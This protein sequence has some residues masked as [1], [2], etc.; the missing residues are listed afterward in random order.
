MCSYAIVG[1][2]CAGFYAAKAIRGRDPEGEIH[3]YS[4]NALPPYNPMLTTYHARGSIA[5]EDL[6]PFG[7]LE[8]IARELNLSLHPETPVSGLDAAAKA[9]R[10]SSGETVRFDRILIASGA[11]A[12]RPPIPGAE[13]PRVLCMRTVEDAV[14]LRGWLEEKRLSSALVVGAS[15]TGIKLAEMMLMHGVECTMVDTAEWLFPLAALRPAAAEIAGRLEARGLKLCFGTSVTGLEEEASGRLCAR[16]KNGG[17]LRADAVFL[18]VGTRA[19]IAF[20]PRD[21][22]LSLD[23]GI[24]V[25][26]F[27][28][29]SSPGIYAAGDCCQAAELQE[30]K[31]II[32]GLWANAGR[33]GQV[34]G[35]NMAGGS[36]CFEGSLV[37]NISHFLDIDFV[38]IGNPAAAPPQARLHAF[39]APDCSAWVSCDE[40]GIYCINLLG[41]ARLSGMIKHLFAKG[42]AVGTGR[43]D[44]FYARLEQEGLP[45]DLLR[46]LR[47][48]AP[49]RLKEE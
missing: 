48:Y 27:M 30:G 5:Y 43:E 39:R 12:L 29:T 42:C 17:F 37:Q 25:D 46:L 36:V 8:Q 3:V 23:R 21:T 31:R 45:G 38:G 16:L 28:Q 10:L 9:L 34:A 14:T 47:R 15:M 33:Q 22:G 11:S 49:P 35:E 1:F 4:D 32:V 44:V 6:F 13:H 18:C 20:L 2:G 26:E 19:N 7:D 24:L 40:A 41:A